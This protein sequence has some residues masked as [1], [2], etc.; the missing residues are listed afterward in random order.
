MKHKK[1]GKGFSLIIL[2][3]GSFVSMFIGLASN[4]IIASYFGTGAETWGLWKIDPGPIN[5]SSHY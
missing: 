2:T 4:I 5:H 3:L 1:E